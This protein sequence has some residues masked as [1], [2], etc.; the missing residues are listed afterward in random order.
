MFACNNIVAINCTQIKTNKR[1][2]NKSDFKSQLVILITYCINQHMDKGF[3]C[4]ILFN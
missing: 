1:Q 3:F 4:L 2:L